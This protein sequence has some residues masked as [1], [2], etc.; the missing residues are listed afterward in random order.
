LSFFKNSLNNKVALVTGA[1]RG[2]GRS[3]SL[4]LAERGAIVI[5]TS[6]T[7]SGAKEVSKHL[8]SIQSNSRGEKLNVNDINNVTNLIELIQK[9]FGKISILVNN[10][11]IT[12]D[13][14][15]IRM[16]DEDWIDVIETN[17]S[18]VFRLSRGVLRG[19]LK[20]KYGRIVNITSVVSA[21]GNVGQVNYAASK[22]GVSGMTRALAK[23]VGSR[24]ITVNCIAPGFVNTEMTEKMTNDQKMS[25]LKQIPLGK[26]A[27]PAEIA[28]ATAFLA[29]DEASYIT[30]TTLHINGGMFMNSG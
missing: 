24:N 7:D 15:S 9:E 23:E 27:D 18:S 16:R 1:S 4:L 12:R 20:E 25:I 17:L 14:L 5:G 29:S 6:T 22:S 10:A 19:M 28:Y 8:K 26:F 21:L 11:G 13:Q 3:I 30:G 2:I